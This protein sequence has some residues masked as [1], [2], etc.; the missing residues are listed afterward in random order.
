MTSARISMARSAAAV[1]VVKYGFPV[2]AAKTTTRP[3][4]RWRTARRRLNGSATRRIFMA[5]APRGGAS[6]PPP[7]LPHLDG[8]GHAGDDPDVLECVLQRQGVDHGR[9]HAHVIGS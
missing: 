7:P 1:S 6:E 9:Q 2:P 5:G 8:R 4:S 3:F